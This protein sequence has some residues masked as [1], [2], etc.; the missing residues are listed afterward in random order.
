ME[1]GNDRAGLGKRSAGDGAGGRDHRHGAGAGHP[2]HQLEIPFH[3]RQRPQRHRRH[4]ARHPEHPVRHPAHPADRAAAGGGGGGL[5]DRIR[6]QPPPDRGD[7]VHQRDAGGHPQHHLR[8]GGYAG[9]QSG[10]GLP[11]LSFVRQPDA[12]SDEP[13]HHHPHH[14]GI[15]QNGAAG[16]P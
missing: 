9:V 5:P 15:P 12:G 4:P 6:L 7:R 3:H 10:T 13:A 1:P 11:D 2:P 16:L 14:A 8:L